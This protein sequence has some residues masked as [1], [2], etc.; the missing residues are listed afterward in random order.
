[1][2]LTY[3]LKYKKQNFF[4]K[5]LLEKEGEM[6]IDRHSFRLKG[7]GAN[8]QGEIIFFSDIRELQTV[9]TDEFRFTTYKKERYILSGFSNLF[10]SFLKDFFRVRNEFLAEQLFM[11]VGM[12]YKEFEGQVEIENRFDQIVPKGKCRIQFYEGSIV[13]V[14]ET[15]EC[16][17][18]YYNFLKSHEFDED[19]YV[20]HLYLDNGTNIHISK[21]GT[22]FEDAQETMEMLLGKM[23]ER[24]INLVR[25]ILPEIPATDLLKLTYIIRDG[26]AVS[27]SAVK[28][29]NDDLPSKLEKLAFAGNPVMD[30]KVKVLRNLADDDRNFSIGFSFYM[31]PDK[32][33]VAAKSWF[34]LAMPAKNI[35][36]IGMTSNPADTTVCFFRIMI[37]EGDSEEK[38]AEMLN[39]INQSMYLLKYDLSA[40]YRDK[41]ELQKGKFRT[42]FRRLAYLRMLHTSYLGRH[43]G[44]DMEHFKKEL[45]VVFKRASLM[46]RQVSNQPPQA[47]QV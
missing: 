1:M 36:A 23:Y 7:K 34:C 37:E 18:V 31:K 43:Y 8:D 11:K 16:F 40:F 3:N 35:V 22:Y 13:V 45:N 25:E 6:I 24:I 26:K 2:A 42:A 33:E 41:R 32:R 4:H 12:L 9:G 30:E 21:L 15:H 5:I 17:A 20:F 29:I 44:P 39:G 10:E 46:M 19:E 14:P 38:L 28:K 47:G 27:L